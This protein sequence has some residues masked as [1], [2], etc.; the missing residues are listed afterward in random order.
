MGH[1]KCRSMKHDREQTN[2]DEIWKKARE[3]MRQR[4]VVLREQG[5]EDA[6]QP[7]VHPSPSE[8]AMIGK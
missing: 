3:R 1:K 2:E 4:P 7:L 8:G 5:Q 6:G